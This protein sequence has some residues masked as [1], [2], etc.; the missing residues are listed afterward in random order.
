MKVMET[1]LVGTMLVVDDDFAEKVVKVT[2]KVL[3]AA[4]VA[5]LRGCSHI[6][7]AKNG[8]L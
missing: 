3:L 5:I 2:K 1:G 4:M 8:G 7:S 6:T